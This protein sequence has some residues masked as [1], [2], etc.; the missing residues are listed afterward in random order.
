[1]NIFS[2]GFFQS[3][4]QK[5][6]GNSILSQFFVNW[7]S[8]EK[9]VQGENLGQKFPDPSFLSNLLEKSSEVVNKHH[10]YQIYAQRVVINLS[11]AI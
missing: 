9:Y 8:L 4:V 1:V 5:R 7:S 10:Y 3:V 6:E 2:T 11:N